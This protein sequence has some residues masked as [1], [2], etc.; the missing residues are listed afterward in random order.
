[1]ILLM[2]GF[3]IALKSLNKFP[4]YLDSFFQ[5]VVCKCTDS[6]EHAMATSDLQASSDEAHHAL[7]LRLIKM[8]TTIT[9]IM[10]NYNYIAMNTHPY[11]R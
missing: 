3:S 8:A 1:M 6:L 7:V 4:I 11:T 5:F 10:C 2:S 9:H